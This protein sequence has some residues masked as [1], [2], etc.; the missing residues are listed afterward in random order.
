MI[1]GIV[2]GLGAA[3]LQA[4]SY[5]CSRLFT[6][7]FH[8]TSVSLLVISHLIMGV[9]ALTLFVFYIPES[10]P[11]FS[12]YAL[13]L[14]LCAFTYFAGQACLFRALQQAH[15]SRVSPLL[16]LKILILAVIS[17]VVFSET[18]TSGQWLAVGVS[19][20][21]ALM[22][23]Q[24]GEK[25][26]LRT[27][28]WILA[29][30]LGYSV[31]DLCIRSLVLAFT[32]DSGLLNATMVSACL[33][34]IICAAFGLILLPTLPRM[35]PRIWIAAIPFSVTWFGAMLFLFACFGVAGVV[36]GNIVQ[37]TR[38]IISVF[39]GVALAHAGFRELE[40]KAPLAVVARRALAAVLMAAAIVLFQ[41]AR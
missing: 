11:S 17:R 34:Y 14:F 1:Q 2:L 26:K 21:A 19:V 5:I 20:V 33:V 6:H 13:P 18:F 24:S 23:R 9:F 4:L 16:G 7:K 15:A 22:L 32:A 41:L 8:A 10:W 25:L 29:A 3:T 30:C 38:G 36:F 39:I 28:F 12:A 40:D 31:S 35:S 37:S 27:L